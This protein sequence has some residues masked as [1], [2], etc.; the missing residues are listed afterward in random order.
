[1][2]NALCGGAAAIRECH[3]GDIEYLESFR[4]AL[5]VEAER[6]PAAVSHR[7]SDRIDEMHER[8]R[9]EARW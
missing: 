2:P 6:T 3:T 9:E 8:Q 1:L 4:E 5:E 7:I